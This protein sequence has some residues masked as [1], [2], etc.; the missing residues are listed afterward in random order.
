MMKKN[1]RVNWLWV[2]G[3]TYKA[4]INFNQNQRFWQKSWCG[5]WQIQ[6]AGHISAKIIAPKLF[7]NP[8]FPPFNPVFYIWNTFNLRKIYWELVSPLAFDRLQVSAHFDWLKLITSEWWEVGLFDATLA[9]EKVSL[10][11]RTLVRRIVW[12]W[13]CFLQLAIHFFLAFFCL[14]SHFKHK[15]SK[16]SLIQSLNRWCLPLLVANHTDCLF[17]IFGRG[18]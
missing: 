10:S 4:A 8:T 15:H 16:P 7:C 17:C 11:S 18:Q 12:K 3:F 14:Q 2:Q 6:E 13:T 1:T 5:H 9:G